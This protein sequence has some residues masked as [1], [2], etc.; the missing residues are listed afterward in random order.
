MKKVDL[1]IVIAYYNNKTILECLMWLL[2]SLKEIKKTKYEILLVDDSSTYPLSEPVLKF[3]EEKKI[4]CFRK[5]SN[6]GVS[7]VRNSAIE[8]TSG[9]IVLFMDA[10]CYVKKNYFKRLMADFKKLKNCG[11]VFGKRE[12]YFD[13]PFKRFREL[14]YRYK[15][16]KYQEK[17]IREFTKK[18][19]HFYLVSGQNMAIK[20]SV[21]REI[22]YFIPNTGCEDIEM[23]YLIMGWGYSAVYD[24]EL[25]MF[26]DHPHEY[27][28]Y[29]K[30]AYKYGKGFERFRERHNISL[31]KNKYFRAYMGEGKI[32]S[33]FESL[34]NKPFKYKFEVWVM[35]IGDYFA[36]K[37]AR[38]MERHFEKK[39]E[40]MLG[41]YGIVYAREGN[42][43]K[44]LVAK[45]DDGHGL[46]G[47]RMD[48]NE[49]IRD[50]F[51]RELDEEVGIKKDQIKKL[52]LT[53]E[54]N[55]FA[56]NRSNG[57]EKHHFFICKVDSN[58]VPKNK[59]VKFEWLPVQKMSSFTK[60]EGTQRI[61]NNIVNEIKKNENL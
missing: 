53:K 32:F 17:N 13:E 37:I 52:I 10:D 58:I 27:W 21:M 45:Y 8:M 16:G 29:V 15:S 46:L 4:R 41:A 6:S 54:I 40:I 33:K 31:L 39:Q 38:F 61:I 2:D 19:P 55:S 50:A 36:N 5:T 9:E 26:H 11:M 44:F 12:P 7:E 23:Q 14:K 47:G 49:S 3:M 34:K 1:S 30:K 59:D 42:S 22:G 24:P 28:H 57:M 35:E 60:W 43:L 20:R 51:V 48:N 18:D 25:V 56:S